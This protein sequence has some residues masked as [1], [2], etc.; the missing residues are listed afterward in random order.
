MDDENSKWLSSY[1]D[2]HPNFI[3]V[4]DSSLVSDDLLEISDVVLIY[5]STVGVSALE[6]GL[7]V[8]SICPE[9]TSIPIPQEFRNIKTEKSYIEAIKHALNE[10]LDV[11]KYQ[12]LES[13]YVAMFHFR[14]VA[15]LDHKDLWQKN[16]VNRNIDPDEKRD[17]KL[18]L[19]ILDFAEYSKSWKIKNDEFRKI[20]NFIDHRIELYDHV[21]SS[22][23]KRYQEM[24]LTVYPKII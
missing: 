7:P 16:S 6:K 22:N 24:R 8:I 23:E 2:K 15:Y 5:Y 1:H 21:A 3:I 19:P 18:D 11:K 20:T 4:E 14:S 9:Q 10:N 12:K 13:S 17:E